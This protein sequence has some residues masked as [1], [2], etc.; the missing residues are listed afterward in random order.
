MKRLVTRIL[1]ML[2]KWR[3]THSKRPVIAVG[4]SIGKTSTKQALATIL[5]TKMAVLTSDGGLNTEIG[6]PLV[7]LE[8]KAPADA[9]SVITWLRILVQAFVKAGM[10]FKHDVLLLELGVDHPGDMD[11]FKKLV[12]PKVAVITAATS[13]HLEYFGSVEKAQAEE[14][15]LASFSEKVV[16]SDDLVPEQLIAA[17]DANDVLL[18]GSAKHCDYQLKV[19]SFDLQNGYQLSLKLKD[20][21]PVVAE[22]HLLG[23]H[24]LQPVLAAAAAAREIGLSEKDIQAGIALLRP[25]AGRMQLLPGVERGSWIID[26]SYNSVAP[27]PVIAA[28]KTLMS[29]KATQ[30]IAVLGSMNELGSF[31]KQYHEEV[32]SFCDGKKLDFVVTIG[33]DAKEYLAPIAA[34][35]GCEVKSYDT[36]VQAAEFVLSQLKPGGLVLVKGSQNKVFSEETVKLLLRSPADEAKL[37]RQSPEWL[38]KKRAQGM[39]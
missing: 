13:E 19:E 36:P 12:H 8:V 29:T 23:E 33:K 32:G 30:H 14:L 37:V 15:K 9:K 38:A 21:L 25:V 3:L 10:P 2:A 22:C 18:Y 26:D 35:A 7:I 39:I 5:G 27:E 28:L 6:V 11:L 20:A 24:S 16:L 34:L 31:S 4:G 1:I 17:L